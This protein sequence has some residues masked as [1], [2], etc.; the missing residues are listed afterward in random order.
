[1][2]LTTLLLHNRVALLGAIT[3]GFI[4]PLAMVAPTWA[5]S[6][7]II[8]IGASTTAGNKVGVEAAYPAQLE[9]M[10]RSKGY[11]VNIRNEGVSG[12]TS[13]SMVG[14]ADSVPS[15]TKL[16]LLQIAFSND[17]KH[18]ISPAQTAANRGAIVAHLQARHIR[19]IFVS[20][21]VPTSELAM[22]GRHPN[23]TGQQS[24]AARLLPQVM[25]AIG[26]H[27]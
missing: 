21:S 25:A 15:D 22:D 1:M 9:A 12:A 27:R 4:L 18:G 26:S 10:L 23:A 24:I 5:A 11:D 8:A 13:A 16:V 20:R 6:I 7:N 17:S 3:A 19:V 14:W 2:S